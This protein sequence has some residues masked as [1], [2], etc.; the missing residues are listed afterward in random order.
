MPSQKPETEAAYIEWAKTNIHADFTGVT[1]RLYKSN[2]IV[3]L[4]SARQHEFFL[5]ADEICRHSSREYQI[6]KGSA[7]LMDER[8]L[9]KNI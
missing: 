9:F 4:L 8:P 7:L 3:S 5:S 6:L 2:A 1:E